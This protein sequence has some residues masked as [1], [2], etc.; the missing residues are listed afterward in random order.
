MSPRLQSCDLAQLYAGSSVQMMSRAVPRARHSPSNGAEPCR[1]SLTSS[2]FRIA[3]V[4]WRY[5]AP[6]SWLRSELAAPGSR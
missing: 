6:L 1:A 4:A 2:P 5:T 3:L